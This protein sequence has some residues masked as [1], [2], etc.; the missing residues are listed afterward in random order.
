MTIQD[1]IN[2]VKPKLVTLTD[3]SSV[4]WNFSSGNVAYWT[5]AGNNT[6]T[7]SNLTTSPVFGAVKIIQGGL[8]NFIP[9]LGGNTDAVT[10]KLNAGDVN[11]LN[12]AYDGTTLYWGS[13]YSASL[14]QL[15]EPATFV[16]T[17]IGSTEIDLTWA[18]VTNATGYIVQRATDSAFTVSLTTIYSSTGTSFNDTGLTLAT[19]YYYRVKAT[20][21][22]YRD[23]AYAITNAST[24]GG[25]IAVTGWSSFTQSPTGTWTSPSSPGFDKA[26]QTMV[27][28]GYFQCDL[29]TTSNSLVLIGLDTSST[30]NSVVD[31]SVHAQ[32]TTA[33][34]IASTAG[35][36]YTIYAQGENSGNALDTG[37]LY[38][39][40]DK[41]RIRR[42]VSTG[43]LVAEKSSDGGATWTTLHTYTATSTATLYLKCYIS[44]NSN[45]LLNPKGLGIS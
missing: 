3:S 9:V 21:S 35:N 13:M 40:G 6:L 29:A 11:W 25:L 7:I 17:V 31:G 37:I 43:A 41:Q 45:K 1:I 33:V 36:H 26:S 16:A 39:V 14:P 18:S 30:A 32:W 4:T 42:T 27:G 23:S 24:T 2:T 44:N 10:W 34:Y 8:G 22:A 28:D 20:A 15:A 12:F 38:T 19:T 5:I